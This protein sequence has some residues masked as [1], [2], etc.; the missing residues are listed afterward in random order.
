MRVAYTWSKLINNG[1]ESALIWG[2]AVQNPVNVA[3]EKGLS[4]D[5]VPHVLIVTY[6]YALPFGK[7]EHWVHKGG[8][9]NQVIGGWHLAGVQRYNSGRPINVTRACETCNFNV[10]NQQRPDKVGGGGWTGG[11]F[12]PAIDRYESSSGWAAPANALSFGNASR[13]DPELRDFP[14]YNEDF[15]LFKEFLIWREAVKLRFETQLGNAFNR[16]YFCTPGLTWGS[17]SFGQVTAMCNQPRHIDFG[18]KLT[19]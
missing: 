11:T 12:D 16:H 2:A 19:W 15:N 17:G 13:T 18:M 9:A 14:V 6:T 5:D 10:G 4:A 8:A 1:A 3:A 7:G